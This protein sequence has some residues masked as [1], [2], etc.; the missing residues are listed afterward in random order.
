MGR[1]RCVQRSEREID[2][3]RLCLG[4]SWSRSSGK[5]C[6]G[7][8]E[9]RPPHHRVL[10]APVPRTPSSAV[11]SP[12]E[13]EGTASRE[14]DWG[15]LEECA[16]ENSTSFDTAKGTVLLLSRG[17]A[18]REYRAGEELSA[19]SPA[20]RDLGSWWTGDVTPAISVPKRPRRP[21]ASWL[22]SEAVWPAGLE[23]R[24][25]SAASTGGTAPS[26]VCGSLRPSSVTNTAHP[27][28][29]GALHPGLGA[30][31]MRDVQLSERVQRG[32]RGRAEGCSSSPPKKG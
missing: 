17:N 29:S 8:C 4:R 28:P 7:T 24:L 2:A 26:P 11:Q 32:P 21:G 3:W 20:E 25:P 18:K 5:R 12:L 27:A 22:L 9:T 31:H 19:S 10:L 15:R 1:L 6:S 14:W 23:K 13:E 16:H 30:Q